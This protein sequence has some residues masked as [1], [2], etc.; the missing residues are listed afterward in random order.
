MS[1]DVKHWNRVSGRPADLVE[2]LPS[3]PQFERLVVRALALQP[4]DRVLD[5]GCGTGVH[6]RALVDAVGPDGHVLAVDY[7]PK[8]VARTRARVEQEGWDNVEVVQVTRRTSTSRRVAST[9][10]SRRGR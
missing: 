1:K 4:G 2:R 3:Q 6:L 8:M 7:S 10:C 9:P 5:L